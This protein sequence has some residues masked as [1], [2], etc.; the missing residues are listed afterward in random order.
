MTKWVVRQL[1]P[2]CCLI[3]QWDKNIK[4]ELAQAPSL[5]IRKDGSLNNEFIVNSSFRKLNFA[6]FLLNFYIVKYVT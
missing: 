1:T 6:H 5:F 4:H 3:Q 2:Y